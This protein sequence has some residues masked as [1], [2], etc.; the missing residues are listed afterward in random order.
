MIKNKVST[1]LDN[2]GMNYTDID[3]GENCELF[4]SEME[5][6]LRGEKS[7][8]KMIPTYISMDKEIPTEEK[9]IVMDAGGTNFRVAGVYFDKDRKPVIEDFSVHPMPGTNG[10]IGREEFF[11]TICSYMAPVLK[12]GSRKIGFC[13]SYPTEIL[14]NRDG[15]LI[16]FCKEVKVK[17]V[18]GLLIGQTLLETVRANGYTAGESI[19]LLN[20]TVATL[21]GGK[22]VYPDRC[23]DSYIGF[24]LGTG[25]NT[26]YVE[27]NENV[28]KVPEISASRGAMLVNVESGAYGRVRRGVID[29]AFDNSTANPGQYVFEK[30]ISGGYQGGLMLAV[31]KKAA[32]DGR[33][34]VPAVN[35]IFGIK[36]LSSKEID[37]FLYYP[38]GSN[39]LARCCNESDRLT[40]FYLIDAMLERAA[41]LVTANLSAVV[42][43]TGKGTDPC[44][45]VCITAEG[46]TFY[47]SK[48]F[49][50]K[51][52][53]YIRTFMNDEK[54][55]YCEFVRADNATLI[56]TAIAAL[57]N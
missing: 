57:L 39:V 49:R 25:T 8:L 46:T 56:G 17:D 3:I 30:M 11:S 18:E 52:D 28:S 54:G 4:L 33:F 6:G 12:Q 23:F 7:S 13:F 36:E 29:L 43:K 40:M 32:E 9:V 45:P 20:D 53:Y 44:N 34:S 19:V 16:Q 1:F 22:A 37:D 55:I 47:K 14:P 48:L 15:R 2:D 27:E 51:L 35:H 38:Y 26:C 50:S 31:L 21:L 42:M 41:K 24:I 5:K 10:E